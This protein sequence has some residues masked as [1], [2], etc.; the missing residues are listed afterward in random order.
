[1]SKKRVSVM[2]NL[3]GGMLGAMGLVAGGMV[4][5]TSLGIGESLWRN[6]EYSSRNHPRTIHPLGIRMAA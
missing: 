4:F 6:E 5:P 2:G 1:M 3:I